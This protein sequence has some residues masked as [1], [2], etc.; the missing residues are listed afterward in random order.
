MF[1]DS[2]YYAE[3]NQF[4]TAADLAAATKAT[5]Y[6]LGSSANDLYLGGNFAKQFCASL[7]CGVNQSNIISQDIYT[8]A[9]GKGATANS[10]R[11][12]DANT[13][14]SATFNFGLPFENA[15]VYAVNL[16]ND[17]TEDS[18]DGDI[19]LGTDDDPVVTSAVKFCQTGFSKDAS[20]FVKISAAALAV[21]FAFLA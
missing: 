14:E 16:W 3:S 6:G 12:S 18:A 11:F 7:G 21:G 1:L 9:R 13:T 2:F 20:S 19:I 15:I 4:A 8:L 17:S 10:K 5:S